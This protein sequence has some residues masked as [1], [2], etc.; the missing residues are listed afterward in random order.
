MLGETAGGGGILIQRG[1]D[2]R[3]E[4]SR[5]RERDAC[6]VLAKLR[7]AAGTARAKRPGPGS[8]RRRARGSAGLGHVLAPARAGDVDADGVHRKA[9]EDR[10]G[11]GGVAEVAPPIAERDVRGDRGGHVPV[12]AIEQVV[13][14]VRGGGFIGPLLDLAQAHVVDDQERRARPAL[15]AAG[16]GTIGEAG[17]EVVDEVDAACVAQLE[18]LLACS[19]AERLEDVAL[20]GAVVAGDHEVVVAAHEVEACELEHEGLVKGGL[21]VPVERLERLALD[22][23]AGVDAPDDALLELVSG[24]EAEDMLDERGGARALVS[25][26]REQLVELV[27]RAGQSEEVEVSS[28]SGDEGVVVAASA[29]SLLGFGWVASLGHAGV[30]SMRD[31]D[32]VVS[33]RR[34][35]SVRS[36]GTVRT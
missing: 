6:H 28:Q 8:G 27:E 10:R 36:R 34:S 21:E 23:P 2:G 9:V 26:P 5:C 13:Q 17:M 16:V 19:Q 31:R 7:R 30:S 11:Q 15:E 33:G 14:G 35:Y 20:A 12:P 25:G 4:A 3:V 32:A 22:E 1:S 29:V 18:P 24:L